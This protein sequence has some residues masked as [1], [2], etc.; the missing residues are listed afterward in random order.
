MSPIDAEGDI[1]QPS[2]IASSHSG[3]HHG[4]TEPVAEP[5]REFRSG[6]WRRVPR[7]RAANEHSNDAIEYGSAN[8]H[9]VETTPA[10]GYFSES[11]KGGLFF[12]TAVRLSQ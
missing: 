5:C 12:L 7:V 8:S 2:E 1:C 6:V 3:G 11:E 4:K 9:D 10:R